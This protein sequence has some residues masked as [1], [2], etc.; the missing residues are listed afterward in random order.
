MTLG[1][2]GLPSS[3]ATAD[4]PFTIYVAPGDDTGDTGLTPSSPVG[5]LARAQQVLRDEAPDSDVEIRISPGTYTAPQTAWNYYVRGHSISF[6]PVGYA[7][8]QD[9]S[10]IQRPVFVGPD[11]AS[12]PDGE[13]DPRDDFWFDA[14]PTTTGMGLDSNLRF[15][16]L[17][18]E[19]YAAGGLR[20][21][22][23]FTT[24]SY[25]VRVPN[26]AGLN[27]NLVE[28]VVFRQ[29]GSS[30]VNDGIAGYAGVDLVNSSYNTIR[31]STFLNLENSTSPGNMHG[32]YFAHGSSHNQAYSNTFAIITG[33]PVK[34]RNVSNDNDISG[35]AFNFTGTMAFYEEQPCNSGT[36]DTPEPEQECPS[37]GNLFHD[38]DIGKGLGGINI[39]VFYLYPPNGG[40]TYAGFDKC[41]TR[42]HTWGNS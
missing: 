16:H 19:H 7:V 33:S 41:H 13:P 1:L 36:C 26:G 5:S 20:L 4:V 21:N 14:T 2:I 25:G 10:A 28:D 12:V 32:V 30:Y 29:L 6:M 22:G 15:Y 18:I 39:S 3:V 11:P 24:D 42:L 31:A 37:F 34:T 27:N 17:Q 40:V 9:A 38:N 23:G 8:G 35:N